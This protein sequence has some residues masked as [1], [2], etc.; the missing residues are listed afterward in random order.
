MTSLIPAPR[1]PVRIL[2]FLIRGGTIA[3]VG[4][5]AAFSSVAAAPGLSAAPVACDPASLVTALAAVSGSGQTGTVT[6][7]PG[8]TYTMSAINNTIDGENAFPDVL[9]SVTVVGNGAT[10]T[11][12]ISAPSFRFFIVDDGGSLNLSN[13]TLSNGS[14][15]LGDLHGGGAILNRS[16]LTVT[17][18]TFL[19]NQS[20][21]TT[22]GGAIDNHDAG[23]LTVTQSTFTGNVGLQGGGIEDEAT[24]CHTSTPNCGKATVIQSTFTNNSTTQYGGGGFEGQLDGPN[25]ALICGPWPWGTAPCQEPGG[26]HDTLV[27]DTFSGNTSI[28][29]GGSIANFGTA[30]LTNSTL[31]NNSTGSGGGG[32][33][34]NTGTLSIVQSTIAANTSAFG[35][36]V[37]SFTDATHTP[38]TTTLTMSI[39]SAGV[40]GANCGGTVAMTDGGY[41]LDDG[42]SC[43]FSTG[44]GSLVNTDP[45]LLPLA[46]NG[47][48]TQTMALQV[49]AKGIQPG[50]P[51][52]NAIPSSFPGCT[53]SFDQRGVSRPQGGACDIGAY[54]ID[55]TPPTVPTGL[56]AVAT[57]TPEVDLSWN[58]STDFFGVTGYM[59]WRAGSP[60]TLL[61]TVSG[62][63]LTYADKAVSQT[64]TYTYMVQATDAAGNISALSASASAT[65]PDIT[66]P[67]VPTALVATATKT[68]EV[69]LSWTASTDN[70]GVTGYDV[71]RNGSSTPLATLSG[72]TL[73]YADKAVS[74]A[75]KYSYK[76]DAFDAAGNHSAQSA[77]ASATT[78]DVT[79]PTVPT[80]LT[81]V[82]TTKPQVN[83]NWNASTDNVGVFGYTIYRGGTMLATVSG[84]TLT[85]ADTAVVDLNS[86]SYTVDAFDAAGNHSAQS[87]PALVKTAAFA[88]LYTL[89]AYGG[90]SADD[91]SPVSIS[92]YWNGWKIA[93]AAK[94]LPGANAAGSGFVLDGYGGLH[95]F[96]SPA[97]VETSGSSG[98]YW[99]WDIARDFAFLPDGTGG[100]VLDGWGGLHP[101][102]VNGNTAPLQAQG[103]AYWPGWDI[104]RKVVIFPDGTGGYVMD[105][106]GGL[107]PFG[108]NGP[109][110]VGA[111]SQSAY[112]PN[113]NIARDVVLVPGDGN[114]SGYV[115]DGYGGLHPFH[116]TAGGSTMPAAIT[117][118]YWGWDIARGVWFLPGSAT[119]G[120]TLDGWGGIH[121]FGGAPAITSSPYWPGRDIAIGAT[122]G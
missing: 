43:G 85:Y 109:A 97:V 122:G 22:G 2:H 66:P 24:L 110:P 30:T 31:Y 9:G 19:D 92:A 4:C 1:L 13:V 89:D 121:P 36:N 46:S 11:R 33:V 118:A 119:A 50:S 71:Y 23:Q 57:R 103:F 90:I 91:S 62:S 87:A 88:G 98:H 86:Y 20:Q 80:G 107:H 95:S 52:G 12:P 105:A 39:V 100:F 111:V 108:I 18:V 40:S 10:I 94:A 14:I 74:D 117:S 106:W 81:A 5:V 93:R 84:S 58:A 28:T 42:T 75:T 27:G 25:P 99:G 51:A 37:H 15:P 38:G 8:C 17:G 83:L 112:W 79:P 96:G 55:L 56:Q 49:G 16:L 115:L 72:S 64:S 101:F 29:E 59:I 76:V 54:E 60:G 82:M 70:V 45:L 78:P 34:Q 63:T 65:T 113:W 77:S 44:L 53:G 69:D 104:A 47:G 41:N 21:G 68:P 61:A 26:A 6:L 120:Y 48:P 116:P 35:A 114:H 67:S 32:G 3:V 7:T 102:R 73:T